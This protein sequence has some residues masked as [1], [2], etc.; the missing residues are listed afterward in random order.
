MAVF[1]AVATAL[2]SALLTLAVLDR[3]V[4]AGVRHV[5]ARVLE[6]EEGS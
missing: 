3:A 1:G 6:R 5:V 4:A 2:L